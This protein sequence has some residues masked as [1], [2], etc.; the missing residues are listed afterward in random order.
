MHGIN[1]LMTQ[2]IKLFSGAFYREGIDEDEFD[3]FDLDE[4]EEDQ[5]DSIADDDEA[6]LTE[7]SPWWQPEDALDFLEADYPSLLAEQEFYRS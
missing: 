3:E 7:D 2:V 6:R 5:L 4:D 1:S